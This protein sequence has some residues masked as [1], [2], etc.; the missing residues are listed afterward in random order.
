M[1]KSRPQPQ[2]HLTEVCP[3]PFRAN[4]RKGRAG[5]EDGPQETK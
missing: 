1:L 3:A 2:A 4:W 5:G